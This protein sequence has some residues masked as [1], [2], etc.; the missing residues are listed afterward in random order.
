MLESRIC[1]GL[2]LLAVAALA[3]SGCNRDW[4]A[5]SGP[6]GSQKAE[7][8]AA[9][10]LHGDAGAVG[11]GA[12]GPVGTP[13]LPGALA[14]NRASY[15]T[16]PDRGDLIGYP[17]QRV[18]RQQGAY[19][20][21]RADV[22]EA[23]ALRAIVDGVL[24]FTTPDGRQLAFE[25]ERHVEH[26]SG[27]WT[28]VG[29]LLGA[30]VGRHA[31]LTFGAEAVFGSIAQP[32]DQPLRLAMRD[33]GSWLVETDAELQARAQ[34]RV[35]RH[36][37]PDFLI[38]PELA[39]QEAAG[40]G[41]IDGSPADVQ[42]SPS[43]STASAATASA[44]VV[45][46]LVGYTPGFATAQGG[47]SAAVTR[48]NFLV[49]IGN[50]GFANSQVD[51][52]LRLVHAMQVEYPDATDNGDT[53]EKLTGYKSGSGSVTPDPAFS[54]L[55]AARE[56]Y[57]ADLVTLVRKFSDPEN[58]GCGIAWLIGGGQTQITLGHQYFGYSVVS[59]GQ[60][61]G[62]D[63]KTYFCRDETMV[64]EFGHN[65]GSAHDIETAKG[66]DGVLDADD[67]GRYP[68][69]FGYRTA[70]GN[71]DFYTIMAY[72]EKRDAAPYQKAYRVF[73]NPRITFCGGF[74]CGLENQAD[75]ARSLG[76]TIPI[77][78]GFRAS[79]VTETTTVSVQ[80]LL[81]IYRMGGSGYTEVYGATRASNYKSSIAPMITALRQSGRDTS[82]KFML[83]DYNRDG[84][85]DLYSVKKM[86]GSGR[87]EVHV[88]DGASGFTRFLTHRAS[89]LHQTGSDDRWT[90]RLGDYNRDG[91]LDV[92]GIQRMGSSGM[93]ELHV[94]NGADHFSSFLTNRTTALA[95][96]GNDYSWKFDVGDFNRDGFQDLYA[97]S[98]VGQAGRTY[99]YILSG[100][101]GMKSVLF[102]TQ[103][104]LHSTGTD[105]SWDFK[106]G[107][108]NRDG[109]LDLYALK[110]N[111]ASGTTE[112]HVLDGANNYRSFATHIATVL[113]PTGTD[114]TW[115]F[116]IAR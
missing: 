63:G 22:S 77:I 113:P 99:L 6:A 15:A 92:Y 51:A 115:E 18:V 82:W 107:D 42:P 89:I 38:P 80:D 47:A 43:S 111:G 97:I 46:I 91:I 60:D 90:F 24:R 52:R 56:T 54:A 100:A 21:H 64:H 17:G 112:V 3:S 105:N 41:S 98:K 73:S 45:D 37:E 108:Y 84:V 76:Q 1:R 39:A 70:P 65:M 10:P 81:A 83:G 29:R 61:Q 102:E 66:D 110:K 2:A 78:A 69:S 28:W 40:A 72:G 14:G 32:S 114:S 25:Y 95:A 59:D 36:E 62:T 116:E 48:I 23:H 58:D 106:L 86:G 35:L 11:A 9:G 96:T 44:T 27:D 88:L 31:I 55:R 50:Q 34:E 4:D 71:G 20:W 104:A 49:E 75:N 19:T 12:T 53:L 101:A 109:I 8:V 67:Y 103:T 94:L 5:N 87:T 79:R 33:G 7:A 30:P 57:G 13:A 26:A 93:T 68:Y 74:A 16:L 85:R